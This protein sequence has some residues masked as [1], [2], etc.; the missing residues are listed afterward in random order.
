[1]L[2]ALSVNETLA[3]PIELAGV[4]L[5]TCGQFAQD[6]RN[7]PDIAE[8]LYFTWAQGFLSGV[9][10]LAKGKGS[11]TRDLASISVEEQKS[12]MRHYCNE[13]PLERYYTGALNLSGK[14]QQL[15][16]EAPPR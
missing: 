7:N 11:V 4:G 1:V 6:Y 9:N 10:M 14:L 8:A 5:K 15:P 13:H 16:P 12:W 3:E 2:L